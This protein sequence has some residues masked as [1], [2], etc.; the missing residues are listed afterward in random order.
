MAT[1]KEDPGIAGA[2]AAHNIRAFLAKQKPT[3]WMPQ[4]TVFI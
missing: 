3:P 1:A 2:A 4:N